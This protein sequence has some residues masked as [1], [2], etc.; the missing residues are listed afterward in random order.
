MRR[1]ILLRHAKTERDAPSGKDRDR[2]LDKRGIGDAAEIGRWLA[3]HDYDRGLAL[4]STA[5]RAQKPGI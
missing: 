1:L 4:V 5:T 3:R 2:Q